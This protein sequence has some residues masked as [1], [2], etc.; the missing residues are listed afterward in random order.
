MQVPPLLASPSIHADSTHGPRLS[1]AT[2]GNFPR[3]LQIA[4]MS[5]TGKETLFSMGEDTALAV[6]SESPRTL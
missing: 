2:P 6:L 3:R 5:Q 1:L 4:D